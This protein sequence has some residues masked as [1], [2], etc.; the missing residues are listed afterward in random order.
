MQLAWAAADGK[1]NTVTPVGMTWVCMHMQAQAAGNSELLCIHHVPWEPGW[2][3]FALGELH[4]MRLL[5]WWLVRQW[6]IVSGQVQGV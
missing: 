1:V 5:K 6:V 2:Y 3:A 4:T